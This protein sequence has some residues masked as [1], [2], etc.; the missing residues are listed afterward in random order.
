MPRIRLLT[1]IVGGG[2]VAGDAGDEL[3]V[4]A[5]T[6]EAWSDGV[7]AER[8]LPDRQAKPEAAVRRDG[9]H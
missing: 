6:A 1:S 7:R 3:E 8:V 2:P 9:G 4:D 5:K